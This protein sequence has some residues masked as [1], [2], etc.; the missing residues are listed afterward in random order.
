VFAAVVVVVEGGVEPGRRPGG[1]VLGGRAVVP[2][3]AMVSGPVRVLR[4][5]SN[6]VVL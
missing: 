6:S 4:M 1:R 3:G 2:F 5:K